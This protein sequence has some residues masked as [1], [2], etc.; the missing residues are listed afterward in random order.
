MLS[1]YVFSSDVLMRLSSESES[2]LIAFKCPSKCSVD[3]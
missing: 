2:M 1:R 3:W